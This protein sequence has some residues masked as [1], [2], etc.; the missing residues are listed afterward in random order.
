MFVRTG[1]DSLN[2]YEY[3]IRIAP[4][5]K[6]IEVPFEQMTDAAGLDPDI[7]TIYGSDVSY[8]S[9]TTDTG[10]IAVYGEPSLSHVTWLG[11]G[12]VNTGGAATGER[13]EVWFDDL[14]LTGFKR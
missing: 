6:S 1:S 2:F 4:G 11:A 7:R 3:G 10:W 14:R 13:I 8:R 12:V 5:W 9:G